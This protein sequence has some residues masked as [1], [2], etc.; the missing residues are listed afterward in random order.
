MALSKRDWKVLYKVWRQQLA[1]ERHERSLPRRHP[2][3]ENPSLRRELEADTN[4]AEPVPAM[5]GAE[6]NVYMAA[7][8]QWIKQPVVQQLLFEKDHSR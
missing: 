4:L 8:S 3:Y 7:Y 2:D 5:P 6:S 1:K